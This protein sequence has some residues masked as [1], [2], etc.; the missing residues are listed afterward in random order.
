MPTTLQF[1]RGT[2]SQNDAFT[3]ALG[4]VTVDTTV[5]SL[6]VH[7]NST[8]GGFEV[9]SKQAKYADVA[10]RYHAD[11]VYEPGTVVSFGGVNEITESTKDTDKKIAGVLSTDPY[12]V[13]NSPHR[14]PDL[15]NLAHPPIALLGKVPTKVVGTV[16]KGD[17]MVSSATAGHARA[18]TE[19]NDPPAGSVIGKSLEDKTS[20]EAGVIEVVI[21]RL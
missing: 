10:E 21:G 11:Q 19:E 7:D 9:N 14:R 4:E 1:R 8:A 18:W 3:G 20:E 6:R 13:M 12:C 16:T 2:T 17:M 5:D 15:T